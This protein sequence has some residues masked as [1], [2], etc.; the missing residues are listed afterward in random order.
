MNIWTARRRAR[1][2]LACL[3]LLS[4]FHSPAA[5][6]EPVL[7]HAPGEDPFANSR[8]SPDLNRISNQAIHN[9]TVRVIAQAQKGNIAGLRDE[10]I[11][12][13][14]KPLGDLELI[15][16]VVA[17]LPAVS[18][19]AVA[20]APDSLYLSSDAQTFSTAVENRQPDTP[21]RNDGRV[22]SDRR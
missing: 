11:N 9:Q 14:G 13:G 22:S 16:A 19:N 20:N 1:V 7:A 8:L 4:L 21:A 6:P 17:E 12:Q 2:L 5:G 3:A 18:L 15:D 10:I